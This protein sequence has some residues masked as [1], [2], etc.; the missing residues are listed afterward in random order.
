LCLSDTLNDCVSGQT[1]RSVRTTQAKLSIDNFHPIGLLGEGGFGKV[2]LMKKKESD[3]TDQCFAVKVM[4]KSRCSVA[5]QLPLD[6][7]S[8]NWN[9]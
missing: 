4:K 2:I 9:V 6:T 7:F 8:L 3:R 1:E 5:T